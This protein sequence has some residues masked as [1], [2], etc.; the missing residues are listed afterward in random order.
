MMQGGA[1]RDVMAQSGSPLRATGAPSG[2]IPAFLSFLVNLKHGLFVWRK[3]YRVP[4]GPRL[5]QMEA[6]NACNLS[7][8]FCARTTVMKRK[9][10][11]LDPEL[12]RK[13]AADAVAAGVRAV[14]FAVF[15]EPL[16]HPRID[17]LVRIAKEA[18]MA[19]VWISSNGSF[20]SQ[21]KVERLAAAGLDELHVCVDGADAKTHE[22]LRAGSCFEKVFA[23]LKDCADFLRKN[24]SRAFR[25]HV[26]MI[27]MKENRH[28]QK[29]FRAMWKQILR[30]VP[31]PKPFLKGYTSF[32]GQ[33]D[34]QKR[35]ARDKAI[36]FRVPCFRLAEEIAVLW[37]GSVSACC[38]D[39]D[40][41]MPVGNIRKD[42]L[43]TIWRGRPMNGMRELHGKGDLD[44][45][46]LCKNCD[47]VN[48]VFM[49]KEFL[50]RNL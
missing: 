39:A 16:M 14:H 47:V 9:I 11:F 41:R 31:H 17:D 45:L 32:A 48:R 35:D 7:C 6:T 1:N 23:Q 20:L 34:F 19:K 15:G 43:Q 44:S 40:G 22:A 33:T 29:E 49:P 38:Y 8:P 24:P 37:D 12:F 5:L 42:S 36:R 27:V 10:G 28:Q 46:P 13:I 18:G 25:L 21:E 4:Q 2:R 50:Q 30:G 3:R 26:Q